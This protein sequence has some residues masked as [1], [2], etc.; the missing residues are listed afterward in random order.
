MHF[1][2][3]ERV[4]LEEFLP[5]LDE[6]LEKIPLLEMESRGNPA[7]Q[8]FRELGG[9]GL[10]VPSECT[11][12]GV[13]LLQLA[14]IQRAIASRS[15]SLAIATTMHHC[16]VAPLLDAS[17]DKSVSALLESIAQHNLYLSSGFAEGRTSTSFLASNM[18]AE[19]TSSGLIVSGSKKP[20]SLSASMDFLTATV[21]VPAQSGDE[22]ELALAIIQADSPGLERRPFWASWVLAGAESDEVILHEV[23]V[24]EEFVSY[25]GGSDALGLTKGLIWFELLISASYLGIASALVERTIASRRGTPA[26]RMLLGIEV[27]GAMAALE[28]VAR[29][30]MLG[31]T[32][33]AALAQTLF[34]RYAVQRAIERVTVHATE[35]LGG[36][37][38]VRSS[39]I[40][41]LLAASR[42]LA[43]HPPSRL[44]VAPALDRYLAGE[45]FIMP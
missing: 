44:S 19:R 29:S 18:K 41:Y 22:S 21:L 13:T 42:A 32:S 36:M 1:L 23:V 17:I 6:K 27:E 16:T 31:E 3:Q 28:G 10:L 24:P 33:D 40:A 7:I 8:I 5:I 11:G 25:L 2:N 26:E 20:C 43:F 37:A 4:T 38:F 34:V 39:E 9:P 14:R 45:P 30:I 35:L 15:P 12:S